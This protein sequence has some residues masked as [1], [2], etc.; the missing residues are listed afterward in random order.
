MSSGMNT[1]QAKTYAETMS[2]SEAVSNVKYGKGIKYRKATMIKLRE[3][4]KIA[5]ML[6]R[7]LIE[8]KPSDGLI[9]RFQID[10]ALTMA[11]EFGDITFGEFNKFVNILD[12]I[13]LTIEAKNLIKEEDKNE[14]MV[15]L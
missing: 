4:A 10:C 5:D 12:K 15:L 11:E 7:L 9:D 1:E 14:E 2:Y 6:D 13:P 8:V 3:L